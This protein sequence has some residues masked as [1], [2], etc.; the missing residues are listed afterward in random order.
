M[1]TPH[2]VIRSLAET[3]ELD[4]A[5]FGGKA[6][7][8][9]RLIGAGYR[10]PSGFCVTVD[11]YQWFVED[12]NLEAAIRM[13]LG[14]K[15]M[16]SMR[17]E[18]VWDAA[19]RIRTAFLSAEIP[20]ELADAIVEAYTRLDAPVVAVRSSAPGED[21]AGRSH[22]GLHESVVGVKNSRG[23]LDAIRVV[24]ASLWSDAALLYRQELG[25]DPRRSRMAVIVQTFVL[26]RWKLTQTC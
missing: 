2:Q 1:D 12:T 23:V 14:R 16:G 13:E 22:A 8:L 17:W 6:V 18:E 26:Q 7:T 19:L 4:E 11:G 3:A 15:P 21:S 9:G 25:M 10:V 20:A 24:W 5:L